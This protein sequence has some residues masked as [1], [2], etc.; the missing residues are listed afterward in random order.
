MAFSE[1]L[2]ERTL[3]RTG[4]T[5]RIEEKKIFIWRD[6][7]SAERQYASGRLEGIAVRPV[8]PRRRQRSAAGTASRRV[9]HYR[10]VDEGRVLVAPEG[11]KNDD[12]LTGWIQR[13]VKFARKLPEK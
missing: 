4:P 3:S 2:A 11:V 9:Q 13:A 8:R 7:F 12:L 6:R 10:A 1:S 5:K